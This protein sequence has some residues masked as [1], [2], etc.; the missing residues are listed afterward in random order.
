MHCQAIL[1]KYLAQFGVVCF[2]AIMDKKQ[3]IDSFGSIRKTAEALG[4]S[5][6]AVYAWPDVLPQSLADK[7]AGAML[8]LGV[9]LKK[10]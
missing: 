5:T 6:Q 2:N 8:R 7:V 10:S 3:I 1:K 9:K 4:L